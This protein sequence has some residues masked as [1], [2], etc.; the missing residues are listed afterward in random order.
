MM[1][2]PSVSGPQY[3]HTLPFNT[4]KCSRLRACRNFQV[5]F[6][7]Q[8]FHANGRPQS[9]LREG[10]G[11]LGN[12][13]IAASCKLSVFAHKDVN[14][15]VTVTAAVRS[16][17]SFAGNTQ[18][19]TVVDTGRNL[20]LQFFANLDGSRSMAGIAFLFDDLT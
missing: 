2:A 9:G 4:E 18:T 1:I 13:V 16:R 8:C 10:Y 11:L 14:I 15:Q 7:V 12:D 19:S 17:F 3:G 20:D 5:N 6:S